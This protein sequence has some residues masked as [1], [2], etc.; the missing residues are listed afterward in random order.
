MSRIPKVTDTTTTIPAAPQPSG[1]ETLV[2]LADAIEEL[3]VKARAAQLP[4]IIRVIA[5]VVK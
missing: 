2:A 1:Y 5:M 4:G 3:P